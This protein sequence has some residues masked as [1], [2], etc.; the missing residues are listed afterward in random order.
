MSFFFLF[1][2]VALGWASARDAVS[3]QESENISA[4]S[5]DADSGAPAIG[6][7][8]SVSSP[9]LRRRGE[10]IDLDSIGNSQDLGRLEA[11]FRRLAD[12]AAVDNRPTVVLRIGEPDDSSAGASSERDSGL[13]FEDALR[14]VRFLG[15]AEMRPLRVVVWLDGR[16]RDHDALVFFAAESVVVSSRA[17]LVATDGDDVT[18]QVYE[19][20]ASGRSVVP[21]SVAGVIG[22]RGAEL[23]LVQLQSGERQFLRGDELVEARDA[24]RVVSEEVLSGPGKLLRVDDE[25][26]RRWQWAAHRADTI[27]D[28][29]ESLD[30]ADL[31]LSDG[32][33]NETAE[34]AV[35]A[36]VYGNLSAAKVRRLRRT[37]ASAADETAE[38]MLVLDSPGGDLTASADLAGLCLDPPP[39]MLR[40]SGV[41]RGEALGDAVI[42]AL[43]CDPLYILS[44]ARLG[45]PGAIELD[46]GDVETITPL[47]IRIADQTGRPLGLMQ[48]ILDRDRP[49][50]RYTN[51]R[52]GAVAYAAQTPGDDLDVWAV[53]ETLDLSAGLSAS[54]AVELGL[55]TGVVDSVD[56]AAGKLGFS[57]SPRLIQEKRWTRWIER[58]G[59]N[60]ALTSLL[61]SLAFVLL[62]AELNAPGIGVPGFVSL[63]C[64]AFYFWTQVLAGT[65]EWFELMT[66]ALG[67]LCLGMEVF[68][69]PGFGIF[70]IGG[71]VLTVAGVILMG[72][73]FV[74]P[75]NDYQIAQLSKGVWSVLIALLL[76]TVSFALMRIYLPSVP[77]FGRLVMD[78]PDPIVVD[79]KERLANY[80]GLLG[81]SGIATTVIRPSGKAMIEGQVVAVISDGDMIAKGDRLRVTEVH[82][83]RIVVESVA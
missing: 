10:L 50:R 46:A 67:L 76:T 33:L 78:A 72:Q 2:M 68:V 53:G 82:G 63:L 4:T 30:L 3:A 69:L 19:T 43:A 20:I 74:I 60:F 28:V 22:G 5:A 24:G 41:I 59:N 8:D 55:A 21:A 80:D 62:A 31:R 6:P 37:L 51:R 26:L 75:H 25:S 64:F 66:L 1:A 15:T 18:A 71:L 81:A 11:R 48:A 45:G 9:G 52:T 27:E 36:N 23:A 77:L 73:S 32:R 7:D 13:A 39:P 16:T 83:T 34:A 42:A 49:V 40:P 38:L 70:G 54:E 57:E 29:A 56:E 35:R 47:L 65:A 12:S 17:Q 79:A 58:L 14:L 44:D 61:L